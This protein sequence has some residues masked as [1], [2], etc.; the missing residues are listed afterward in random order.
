MKKLL[1]KILQSLNDKTS[2][3]EK[4]EEKLSAAK[5]ASKHESLMSIWYMYQCH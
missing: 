5:E 3:E 1:V 2:Q 4:K